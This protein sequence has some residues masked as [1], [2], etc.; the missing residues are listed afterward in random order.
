MSVP[1][2][3]PYFRLDI[4]NILFFFF[5]NT[6]GVIKSSQCTLTE[7]RMVITIDEKWDRQV[8]EGEKRQTEKWNKVSSYF[9]QIMKRFL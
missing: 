6:D 3:L 5:V 1:W 9:I 8:G 7:V 4:N 2:D